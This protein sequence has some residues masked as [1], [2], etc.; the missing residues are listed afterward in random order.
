MVTYKRLLD[1]S[2]TISAMSEPEQKWMFLTSSDDIFWWKLLVILPKR[3][4]CDSEC[5][6][7]HWRS[8]WIQKGW[9]WV[10]LGVGLGIR[11]WRWA[12]LGVGLGIWWQRSVVLGI[13]KVDFVD[14]PLDFVFCNEDHLSQSWKFYEKSNKTTTIM[15]TAHLGIWF[16]STWG[17]VSQ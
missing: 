2:S 1:L 7:P 10:G 9:R 8:D 4:I 14:F 6:Y 13:C 16:L 5:Q 17:K 12:G 11:G 15:F 3:I